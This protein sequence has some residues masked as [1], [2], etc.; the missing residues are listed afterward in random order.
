MTTLES[1]GQVITADVLVIGHGAGGLVTAITAKEANPKLKV[2]AVDKASLGFGGKGNKGGGHCSF[3]PEGGDEKYVEY[4]TRNLGDYL[5][6]QDLLLA[7]AR[8]TR[9]VLAD[10]ERWGVK[11]FGKEAPFNAHPMIPW[12]MV[13]VD[14]DFLVRLAHTAK[15]LG[16]EFMDKIAVV[17]LLTDGERV[18]GAIGF[19][20]LDG[21][22]Y[23]YKAKA[24][25]LVNGNQNWRIMRL[26]SSGRGDGIAAAYRAGAKMRN[27]EFGT[28]INIVGADHHMVSYGAEDH[29][30]NKKGV[31]I[32]QFARP[33]MKENSN[34]GILGGVDLGGNHSLYMYWEVQK[35][36]GPIYENHVENDFSLSW[37]GKNLL[38]EAGEADEIWNRPLAKK[39]W[40]RL[41]EKKQA[42]YMDNNPMKEALPGLIGEFGPVYTDHAMATSLKGL[43]A[44]G[45]ICGGGNSAM[46]AVPVPPGRNR[47]AGLMHAWFTARLAGGS[48]AAFAGSTDEPKANGDQAA[49]LKKEMFAPLE[50]ESGMTPDEMVWRV[51]NVMNP[52]KYSAWKHEDRLKEALQIVLGLKAK[53]PTLVAKDFHYL[54]SVNECHSMVLTA[55]MFFRACLARKESRGWFIREDYPNRDDKNL[56]KWVIL[57]KRAEEMAVA[58]EDVPLNRYKYQPAGFESVK[59]EMA[60]AGSDKIA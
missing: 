39:F 24:I 34:L 37:V 15:K 19:S 35:G 27:A 60:E 49:H 8:S 42:S 14:L 11:L 4:H 12:K 17:D 26:W 55:E 48:A 20:L 59:A 56:P 5:N 44:A 33:F 25:V 9:E 53:I 6:D 1:L 22:T 18:V 50:R 47:G 45:D 10:L 43:F 31:N 2:L 52:I 21:T 32:T 30:Y 7:Y 28:F 13:T 36:D 58:Y 54:C 46:G 57:Q 38:P 23:I 3:I 51:Q 40:H 41:Y 29:L 16:I